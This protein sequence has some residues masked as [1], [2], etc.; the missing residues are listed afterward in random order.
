[1]NGAT[2]VREKVVQLRK[3]DDTGEVRN[4]AFAL[5]TNHTAPSKEHTAGN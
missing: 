1:M 2:N 5:L 4:F 3:K